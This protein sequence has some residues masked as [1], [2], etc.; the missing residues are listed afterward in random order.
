MTVV[1]LMTPA[2]QLSA[3][4][5]VD[6]RE[7]R[8][9]LADRER[10]EAALTLANGDH[11]LG[12]KPCCPRCGGPV[13]IGETVRIVHDAACP[14]LAAMKKARAAAAAGTVVRR[15]APVRVVTRPAAPKHA[16]S[17]RVAGSSVPKRRAPRCAVRPPVAGSWQVR[18]C[19]VMVAGHRAVVT[20]PVRPAGGTALVVPVAFD[21]GWDPEDVLIEFG[22]DG[23]LVTELAACA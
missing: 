16:A 18:G 12:A 8:A 6:E 7:R 22:A 10:G 14:R 11:K 21:A 17:D 23:E 9:R 5:Q 19:R 1:S 3:D 13:V 2:S 15:P 4:S 20:G